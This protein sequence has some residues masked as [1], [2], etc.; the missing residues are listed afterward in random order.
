MKTLLKHELIYFY[1]K[2]PGVIFFNLFLLL[3]IVPTS[4]YPIFNLREKSQD[5]ALILSALYP[6][7]VII[8][9]SLNFL[10]TQI[11]S[12]KGNRNIE[13]LLGIGI[14]PFKILRNKII[15]VALVNYLL[16]LIPMIFALF[17]FYFI[18][19]I[20]FNLPC[21]LIFFLNI[22]VF[23]PLVGVSIIS[24]IGMLCLLSSDPR[25]IYII[26]VLGSF[27]FFFSF[28]QLSKVIPFKSI[29]Q[30]IMYYPFLVILFLIFSIFLCKMVLKKVPPEKYL[31]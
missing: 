11:Y 13:V 10:T 5:L 4:S 29:A 14:T 28:P 2:S 22:F 6:A 23:S 16:Y 9:C 1:I 24:I 31:L 21:D 26:F 15:S 3:F 17:I 19:N 18:F 30:F 25:Y 27:L 8:L 20:K 7:F 12:E